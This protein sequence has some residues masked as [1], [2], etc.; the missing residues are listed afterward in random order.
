M[1]HYLEQRIKIRHLRVIDALDRH[2]SLLKASRTLNVTQPALTRALQ[3]IEDIVGAEIF[4]RHARGVRPNVVGEVLVETARAVLGQ[5]RRAQDSL[6]GLAQN[7]ASTITVG[8]LPVAASGLLPAV[9][10]G[11]YRSGPELHVRLLH[12]RTDELLPRLAS[13]EI[14]L[15]IGRLYPQL[16]GDGFFRRIMYADPIALIARADHAIFAKARPRAEHI[17]RYRLILPTLSQHVERDVTAVIEALGISP[18][19]SLRAS[20]TSFVRELLL[21]TD[22]IAIMPGMLVAGDIGRGELR[23]LP[24]QGAAQA[25][26]GGIILKSEAVAHQP[27][28]A[29]LLR[30]LAMQLARMAEKGVVSMPDV[31]TTPR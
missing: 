15:V 22:S 18:R 8:A 29:K 20:S 16:Q 27:G 23:A 28:T 13:G 11:L 12:G 2:K 10:S 1:S 25:R 17:N 5:L 9:L 26:P 31:H 3:E 4:E 19:E 14:D 7:N 30:E 6:E 21:S 24:L